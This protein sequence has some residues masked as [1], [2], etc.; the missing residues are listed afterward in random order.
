MQSCSPQWVCPIS[1]MP[2]ERKSRPQIDLRKALSLFAGVRP[3]TVLPGQDTP[4]RLPPGR[5]IDFV[6]IREKHR[7]AFSSPKVVAR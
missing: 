3:V 1:A 4:L 7:G 5:G 2:T 6:L